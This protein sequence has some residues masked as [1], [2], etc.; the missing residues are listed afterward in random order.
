M[1][2]LFTKGDFSVSFREDLHK[3]LQRPRSTNRSLISQIYLHSVRFSALEIKKKTW[4]GITLFKMRDRAQTNQ[5][6][7]KI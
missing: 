3:H 1:G 5:E 2:L 7:D 6:L 4:D